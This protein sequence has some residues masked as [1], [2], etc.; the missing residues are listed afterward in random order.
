MT[1]MERELTAAGSTAVGLLALV[2]AAPYLVQRGL[3][4][5]RRVHL[6]VSLCRSFRQDGAAS[7]GIIGGADGPTAIYLARRA[8]VSF[9]A[10]V[11]A[12]CA[13]VT[14][15]CAFGLWCIRSAKRG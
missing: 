5:L 6:R 13:A 4:A 2:Q 8:G 14:A 12:V 9:R 3:L 15:A 10:I 7:I 1:E 11:S